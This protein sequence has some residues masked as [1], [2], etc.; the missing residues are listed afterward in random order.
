MEV[1]AIVLVNSVGTLLSFSVRTAGPITRQ[2]PHGTDGGNPLAVLVVLVAVALVA[3]TLWREL[4][5]P[6]WTMRAFA[7]GYVIGVF[8]RNLSRDIRTVR[9]D[10]RHRHDHPPDTVPD[11]WE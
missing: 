1:T 6:V 7:I 2:S 10:I 8:A 3:F 9:D 4:R 11:D 5:K